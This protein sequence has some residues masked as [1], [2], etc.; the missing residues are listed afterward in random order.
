MN[1]GNC[2]EI[3]NI[4]CRLYQ[5]KTTIDRLTTIKWRMHVYHPHVNSMFDDIEGEV[6]CLLL[7]HANPKLVH[8]FSPCDGWSTLYILSTLALCNNHDCIVRS[9]DLHEGSKRFLSLFPETCSN[10]QLVTGD[11]RLH[12][13]SFN[14]EIDYLFIDSDHSGEFA[15]NYIDNLLIP[16][17]KK[18][19][20]IN[21]RIIVS[22]HDIFHSNPITDYWLTQEPG[23]ILN[24]LKQNNIP[25]F[26][27]VNES[28]FPQI[29]TLRHNAGLD[30]IPGHCSTTNPAIFFILG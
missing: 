5:D 10:W 2:E 11:V 25:Y 3:F 29:Q 19:K 8:E 14:D 23:V 21:K 16:L 13:A 22:V 28:I 9:Y 4:V 24:F 6:L 12:F 27:P 20:D 30:T 7:M 1:T 17:Q 18:L 15:K 26:S